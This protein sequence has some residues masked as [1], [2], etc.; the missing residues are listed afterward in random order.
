MKIAIMSDCHDN[1][2]NLE[3]AINIANENSCSHLL[4]AGDFISPLGV[5]ILEKFKGQVKIVWGNNEAEKIG[6]MKRISATKN[7]ELCGDLFD[8]EISSCKILM[9]HYP[10]FAQLAAKS[11]EYDLCIHGHTHEYYTELIGQT[12]LINPGEIHGYKTGEVGFA[13]YDVETQD[14]QRI[15]INK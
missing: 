3:K 4:F 15:V 2:E 12:V 10:R 11:Q 14:V 13:I 6:M 9:N 5:E 8:G 7:V 1:W